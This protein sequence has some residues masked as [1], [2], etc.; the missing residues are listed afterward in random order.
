MRKLALLLAMVMALSVM[1]ITV[2]ASESVELEV[3]VNV[4]SVT[5]DSTDEITYT[6]SLPE[7][8]NINGITLP[9]YMI[10]KNWNGN[11][12]QQLVVRSIRRRAFL[13]HRAEP[14]FLPVQFSQ[15]HLCL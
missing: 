1:P 15:L 9:F 3:D 13:R 2:F 4:D 8:A 7:D 10:K 11:P 5:A 6:V 12:K 14:Q